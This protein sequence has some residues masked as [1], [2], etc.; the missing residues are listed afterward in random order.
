MNTYRSGIRLF[1]IYW[2]FFSVG[3][4]FISNGFKFAVYDMSQSP[5]LVSLVG[6]MS[7]V[8]FMTVGLFAG[9]VVSATSNRLFIFLHL[10]L[11]AA[12]SVVIYALFHQH[13]LTIAWMF[14]FILLQ[15]ISASFHSAAANRVFYDLAGIE[16][17]SF[18]LS[19]RNI[20]VSVGSVTALV[21]LSF[22]VE[23]SAALFLV[24]ALILLFSAVLFVFT[25]YEDSNQRQSFIGVSEMLC[26]VRREFA[27]F[28]RF[29]WRNRTVR[30]LFLLSFLKT[31][32]IYWAMSA[33]V[34]LKLG[35]DS[36]ESRRLYLWILM[37]MDFVNIAALY[38]VGKW[39]TFSNRSFLLGAGVSALGI[40]LFA[41]L[42][43]KWLAIA[44]LSLMHIGF[45]I[46]QMASGYVLRLALPERFR[47][48]GISFAV[49]PYYFA[50]IVSGVFF[51]ALL[52]ILS[53]SELLV[54]SGGGLLALC[55][56]LIPVISGDLILFE[57]EIT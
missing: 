5:R 3:S 32:F 51:A 12:V 36:A 40:L 20:A 35:I 30:V 54:V 42:S 2:L 17:L 44:A 37:A 24:Y 18:W 56:V 45:A 25:R 26:Y 21:L 31:F 19:K 48:Q 28:L 13:W 11:F 38:V 9:I 55:I 1:I 34:L 52:G 53:V 43:N 29:S 7:G 10:F 33:G 4:I 27:A 23:K 39:Q 15:G 47:T 6:S 14:F 22:F 46:S 8:A 41:L 49:I 50:D 16:R 57:E